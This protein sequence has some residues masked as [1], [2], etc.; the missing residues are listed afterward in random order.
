MDV[1]TI[2]L[3]EYLRRI[4]FLIDLYTFL[5]SKLYWKL[6]WNL[7]NINTHL[8]NFSS[9]LCS[10]LPSSSLSSRHKSSHPRCSIEKVVLKIRNIHRKT[11]VLEPLFNKVSGLKACNF[12]KKRV[13]HRCFLFLWILGHFKED[14]FWRTSA[15]YSF[16][17]QF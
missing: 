10:T 15:N 1:L 14:L 2:T 13:Q 16:C 9:V 6:I 17:K 11:P 12:I 5:F 8:K 4:S 7:K 3:E